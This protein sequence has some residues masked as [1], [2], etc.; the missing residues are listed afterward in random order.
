MKENEM[1]SESPNKKNKPELSFCELA[2]MMCV[3]DA[4]TEECTCEEITKT[5]KNKYNMIYKTT[6]IYTYLK[7]LKEKGFI[8]S[9]RR[10]VYLFYATR[11]KEEYMLTDMDRIKKI[12]FHNDEMK[13]LTS[14]IDLF[15]LTDREKELLRKKLS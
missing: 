5:L 1:R 13:M 15:R 9:K 12:W 4:G 14:L 6:T 2:V 11:S 10:G 7:N 8:S 3:W